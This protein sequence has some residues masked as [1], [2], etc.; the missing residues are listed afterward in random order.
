MKKSKKVIKAIRLK[1]NSIDHIPKIIC[2][3]EKDFY[4]FENSM[5]LRFHLFSHFMK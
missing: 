2:V 4:D 3:D 5:T 1:I